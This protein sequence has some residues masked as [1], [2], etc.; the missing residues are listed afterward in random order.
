MRPQDSSFVERLLPFV[1]ASLGIISAI[2]VLVTGGPRLLFVL[3]GTIG[4]LA[5]IAGIIRIRSSVPPTQQSPRPMVPTQITPAP[6]PALVP[7][8]V[9]EAPTPVAPIVVPTPTVPTSPFVLPAPRSLFIGREQELDYLIAALRRSRGEGAIAVVGPAG[10]GKNTLVTRALEA[11]ISEDTFPD[12]FSW[13]QG[14]D[15]HGDRGMRRVLI[16]ILDRFG[17][18][19]VAMTT[20]LR[21]GESAVAELVRGKKIVFWL[22]DVPNDFPVGRAIS[23]LTARDE[24]GVGPTLIITSREDWAIPEVSEIMVDVPQ[25]DEAL[26]F[27]REWMELGGRSEGSSAYDAIKA[28]CVNLSSLPLALR[29]AAG[30]AAQSGVKLPKLAADLGSAV[31]PPGDLLRTANSTIAFVESALFPQPRQVFAALGVFEAPTFDLDIAC[32]VAAA[33]SGG[34]VESTQADIESMVRLGLIEPDGDDGHPQLRMHPLVQRYAAQQLVGLGPD[35]AA[36]ARSTLASIVHSRRRN[37]ER[38]TSAR[39]AWEESQ[40][41]HLN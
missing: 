33:V 23:A 7:P 29:L 1:V 28:I 36:R 39:A 20:T 31:Y 15:L 10:V 6:L 14:T 11:H 17:G 35:L 12:G 19:A 25:L 22:D 18:P 37:D 3:L 8:P 16:E 13:H 4:S 27:V 30:Y 40:I 26:D 24:A 21:M 2:A 38:D 9:V 5:L 32:A 41:L 34:T